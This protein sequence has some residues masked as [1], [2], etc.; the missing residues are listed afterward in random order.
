[1]AHKYKMNFTAA[2]SIYL[3]HLLSKNLVTKQGSSSRFSAQIGKKLALGLPGRFLNILEQ[4]YQLF[5][6]GGYLGRPGQQRDHRVVNDSR[7]I[8]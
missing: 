6:I 3:A 4:L 8:V 7:G 1:M 2:L 5:N